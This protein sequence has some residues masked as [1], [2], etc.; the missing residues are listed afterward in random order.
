MQRAWIQ[1]AVLS[2]AI[3]I[4]MVVGGVLAVNVTDDGSTPATVQATAAGTNVP[5]AAT[6]DAGT[7][8]G[9]TAVVAAAIENLPDLV[10]QV[11]PSVVR[12]QTATSQG[13]FSAEG[14][15]S[16]VVIDTEG[17]ILT[18][19]HVVE[20]ATAVTVIL[21][22]GTEATATVLGTDPGNDLA[23]IRAAVQPQ[24]LVPA[25]FGNSDGVRVGEPVF[26]IGNPFS[27]S[28]SVTSGIVSAVERERPALNG[29]PIRSVIQTDAAVNPGNS[30]GPLFNGKGEVIGINTSI[31]NPTGQGVFVG[32]GFAV[33]SNTALRFIPRLIDGESVSHPQLG[34]GGVDLTDL[35]AT[36]LGLQVSSGVYVTSVSPGS[37]AENAG[38]RG[39]TSAGAD[40]GLPRGGDVITAI[41]GQDV[42]SI[43]ALAG[44]IDDHNVG[45]T[46]T[47]TVVRGGDTLQL[48]ATLQEWQSSS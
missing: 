6:T 46:V 8:A 14:V 18:N 29:R 13:A 5:I 41:D 2:A 33:P 32:I 21:A 38:L 48:E 30:G 31:E 23:V 27:L 40:G 45:D 47:L 7:S 37:G 34:I 1:G 11:S 15:G 42:A 20:D 35:N 36:D 12:I 22:D 9:S 3:V 39:P 43:T 16:G 19:Y 25:N 4:S 44:I 28:F 10:A 26:A 17:H 24:R